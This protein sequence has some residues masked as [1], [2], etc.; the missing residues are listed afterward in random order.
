MIIIERRPED[1]GSS[2]A[3]AAPSLVEGL[4]LIAP[5]H[6]AQG[7]EPLP[8]IAVLG[9]NGSRRILE[10]R[11][12]VVLD[13]QPGRERLHEPLAPLRRARVAGHHP[14]GGRQRQAGRRPVEPLEPELG[15]R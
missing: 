13:P 9:V 3:G 12:L 1:T 14:Q 11:D 15:E 4:A 5:D 7:C 6:G 10:A 8:G 2:C